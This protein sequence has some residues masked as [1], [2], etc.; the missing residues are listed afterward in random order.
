[1]GDWRRLHNEELH[2]S[3]ASPNI[4]RA[5]KSRTL[6]WAGHVAR[7]GKIRNSYKSS[8]GDR[9]EGIGVDGKIILEW[10]FGN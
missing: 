8:V 7:M 5:I 2:N 9:L 6:S 3:N 10:I 4:I 1:V